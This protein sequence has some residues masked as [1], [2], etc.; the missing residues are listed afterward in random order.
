MSP[1]NDL[2]LLTQTDYIRLRRDLK[3]AGMDLCYK[4]QA[5][6]PIRLDWSSDLFSNATF[7]M[8][9]ARQRPAD[10]SYRIA[11]VWHAKPKGW[12][13][14]DA[15]IVTFHSVSDLKDAELQQYLTEHEVRSSTDVPKA[16]LA[17]V[18]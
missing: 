5:G 15:F 10:P 14:P 4:A 6:K 9:V 2:I 12:F 11:S 8:Q 18:S 17:L 3:A 13:R 16:N 7:L 1:Q